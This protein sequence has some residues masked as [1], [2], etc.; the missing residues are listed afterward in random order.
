MHHLKHFLCQN[1][2]IFVFP[3]TFPSTLYCMGYFPYNITD[4]NLWMHILWSLLKSCSFFPERKHIF[5]RYKIVNT[6]KNFLYHSSPSSHFSSW[7]IRVFKSLKYLSSQE[8]ILLK[9]ASMLCIKCYCSIST[10]VFC[11]RHAY[12]W[13]ISL[14]VHIADF[15][16][17]AAN[18]NINASEMIELESPG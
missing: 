8:Y 9:Y 15:I 1:K 12:I 7:I 14:L 11:F 16:K 4:A 13:D 5:L 6:V 17:T 18:G 10:W 2:H 3:Q